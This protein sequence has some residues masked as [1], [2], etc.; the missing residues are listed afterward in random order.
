MRLSLI[1]LSRCQPRF[2]DRPPRPTLGNSLYVYVET[3]NQ[4]GGLSADA[5]SIRTPQTRIPITLSDGGRSAA[6][7]QVSA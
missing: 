3:K 7:A 6:S 1:P 4:G 2:R 5:E